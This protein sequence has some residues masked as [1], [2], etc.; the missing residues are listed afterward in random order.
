MRGVDTAAWIEAVTGR[1]TDGP[2]DLVQELWSGYGAIERWWLDGGVE[3][4]PTPVILKRIER[5]R[6][7]PD[8]P[9]GWSSSFADAR[10]RRSYVIER[11]FY[12]DHAAAAPGARTA[13]LLGER[14]T[15]SGGMMLLEDLDAA[16]FPERRGDASD[17]EVRACLRWLAAFHGA[18]LGHA[19]KGL[20]PRGTYWHLDTRPDELAA[21]EDA[22]LR[23]AAPAI[24][25]R[26][27]NATHRTLLHGDAKVA[28]FCFPIQ[29]DGEQLTEVAAVDL[30]YVGGGVGVQDVAYFLGSCLG[31]EELA[32]SADAHLDRYF[33][34]LGRSLAERGLQSAAVEDEW[35]AL[36][37]FAWADFH[38]FLAGWAPGHW[39]L[40]TFS[41][42]MTCAAL[43]ELERRRPAGPS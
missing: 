17:V 2:P 3:A 42:R 23:E 5:P 38:R 13:Q 30:Q 20:W 25:Q 7:G 1:P 40:S 6:G 15:E 35:R 14:E 9:R 16:G 31:E 22:K 37:A 32:R 24:D 8:H 43:E 39:K 26:L 19:P 33:E 4:R 36:W 10:K 21:T 12:R 11:A 41:E 28:N 18:F 27:G 29:R 34:D